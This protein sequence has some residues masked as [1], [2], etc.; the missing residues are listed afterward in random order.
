MTDGDWFEQ[1]TKNGEFKSV[2]YIETIGVPAPT[3]ENANINYPPWRTKKE[4]CLEI[5]KKMRIPAY[6]V[7]HNE[8][9]NDFLVLRITEITP[10]RMNE[11][12]YKQFIQSL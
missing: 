4:L 7:W 11:E 5:E 9:C 6:V 2:A 8:D 12:E 10:K 3:I 1:R